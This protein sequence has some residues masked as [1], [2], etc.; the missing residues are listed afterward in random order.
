MTTFEQVKE[1]IP[2]MTSQEKLRL[3]GLLA[4]DLEGPVPGIER[5]PGICGGSA[6]IAGTRIPVWAI[7]QYTRLG[8]S[9]AELL[10]AYPTISADDLA[11]ALAY[12]RT[13][14]DEIANEI[15]ENEAA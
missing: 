14:P 6:R 8:V 11:N 5:T 1:L 7:V 15:L 9:Q 10:Q 13:H 4:Q 12:Y 3:I 2:A